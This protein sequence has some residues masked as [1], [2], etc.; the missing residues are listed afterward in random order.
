MNITRSSHRLVAHR[1]HAAQKSL[2]NTFVCISKNGTFLFLR[3]YMDYHNDR[4]EDYSLI[5]KRENNVVALFPANKI[6]EEVHS[7][8]GLTYGG[9]VSSGDMTTPLMLEIFNLIRDYF[10][11]SGIKRLHYKT[12]PSIYHRLP[13]EEDRYALFRADAVLTRRDVLSV[14][15]MTQRAPVQLRRRRGAA[16][17]GKLGVEIARSDDWVHYWDILTSH[18]QKWFGHAP[19]HSLAEINLLRR[20]FP[21]NIKLYT[22]NCGSELVAGT[23]IYE[24][25]TVAHVQYVASSE[26]G[27]DLGALDKLFLDLLNGPYRD[28]LFFDFGNSNGQHERA[29]NRGLIE[30][31]EGFGGRAVV[32]DFY[33]LDFNDEHHE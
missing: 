31:K 6:A 30:Q 16:K 27:R 22:A 32:H 2:W 19:V 24:S 29:L 28:R 10:R 5:I 21:D 26:R 11:M 4:F 17:A 8:Q 23:V 3:D 33:R 9:F 15:S 12:I 20:R 18:Q 1:Y 14:V 7:H 25:A 13:A